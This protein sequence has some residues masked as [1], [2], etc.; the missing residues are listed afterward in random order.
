MFKPW[1]LKF[2]NKGLYLKRGVNI[3]SR[4]SNGGSRFKNVLL[5]CHVIHR[6]RRFLS[7]SVNQFCFHPGQITSLTG[8]PSSFFNFGTGFMIHLI[9]EKVKTSVSKRMKM[10]S[11]K[12]FYSEFVV[13]IIIVLTFHQ[14]SIELY[15]FVSKR[16]YLHFIR[17]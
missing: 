4:A 2:T 15:Q 7:G 13:F 14:F 16:E 11:I 3:S 6:I 9:F 17:L 8:E 5:T 12:L 1:K 10:S